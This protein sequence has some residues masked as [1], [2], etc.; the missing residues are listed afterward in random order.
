MCFFKYIYIYIHPH[1]YIHVHMST[2][3][4]Y[5]FLCILYKHTHVCFISS[6]INLLPFKI[7]YP[8]Q[9]INTFSRNTGGFHVLCGTILTHLLLKTHL[10]LS[11]SAS[12]L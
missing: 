1:T 12:R 2:Q 4:A 11:K 7:S 3:A 5:I 10:H 8:W 9:P 6:S